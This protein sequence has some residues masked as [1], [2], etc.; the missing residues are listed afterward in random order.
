MTEQRDFLERAPAVVGS[1]NEELVR[2]LAQ[3]NDY[4]Q[5][6]SVYLRKQNPDV[7]TVPVVHRTS[8]ASNA[9]TDI[10]AHQVHFEVGGKPVPIYSLLVFSTYIHNVTI[11]IQ[12]LANV[13]DGLVF[14]AGDTIILPIEIDNLYVQVTQ[15]GASGECIVN[16]PADPTDGAFFLFGFTIPDYDKVRGAIRST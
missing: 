2:L 6:I 16:G 3:Q 11:N 14:A 12:N 5:N 1:S 9:I 10:I 7:L 13:N 4:L 15:L 8:Q